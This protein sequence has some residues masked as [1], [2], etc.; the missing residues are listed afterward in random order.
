MG[1]HGLEVRDSWEGDW[2]GGGQSLIIRDVIL[3]G[4]VIDHGVNT[5]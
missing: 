2:G 3:V 1:V 4:S 5:P